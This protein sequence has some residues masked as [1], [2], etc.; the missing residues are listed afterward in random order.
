[1]NAHP[2]REQIADRYLK[3]QRRLTRIAVAQ[4]AES[5]NIDPDS[6]EVSHQQEEEVLEQRISLN[7]QRLESVMEVLKA[8]NAKRVV[9]LG[10]GEGKLLRSLLKESA[11]KQITGVDVSHRALE[12]GLSWVY[13]VK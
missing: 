11:I 9:D 2:A 5:D 4:L 12:I 13:G 3:R 8:S 1:M 7:Q 6:V 10:C